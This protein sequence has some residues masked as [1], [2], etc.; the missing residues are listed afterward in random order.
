M[1][2]ALTLWTALLAAPTTVLVVQ[3]SPADEV[4]TARRESLERAVE[5]VARGYFNVR[6]LL[7]PEASEAAGSGVGASLASCRLEPSCVRGALASSGLHRALLLNEDHSLPEAVL[8]ISLF[9]VEAGLVASALMGLEPRRVAEGLREVLHRGGA[10][11]GG[12]VTVEIVTPGAQVWIDDAP[13]SGTIVPLSGGKHI[14]RATAEGHAAL[15]R[16]LS[17]EVGQE[18]TERV[19]LE[20]KSSWYEAPVLWG[21]AGAVV[22]GAILTVAIVAANSSIT[23][24]YGADEARCP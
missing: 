21:A 2:P 3:S 17:V 16:Q 18:S 12:R 13:V 4:G 14:L 24:C 5:E 8:S 7:E 22:V 23:Y 6:L 10:R 20:P 11:P 15:L 9:D 1:I 19:E